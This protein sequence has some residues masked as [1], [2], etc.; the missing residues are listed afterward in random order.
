MSWWR[1]LLNLPPKG[2]HWA[3]QRRT[4]Q[5]GP[6]G[7]AS[8]PAEHRTGVVGTPRW[9]GVTHASAST[10]RSRAIQCATTARRGW[11]DGASSPTPATAG[12]ARTTAP[13]VSRH[14]AAR[15]APAR[16]APAAIAAR[17]TRGPEPLR[18]PLE[19]NQTPWSTEPES[20]FSTWARRFF[21]G[22]VVAV[23][24]LAAISGVR[25][26]IRP[27]NGSRR[28]VISGQSGYP[29]RTR[30]A[31]SRPG[32]PVSYLNWDE[33][34]PD[35]RPAQLSLDLASGLDPRS[36]WNGRGKQTAAPAYAG[37]VKVDSGRRR[38]GRRRPRAGA[39]VHQERPGW[40]GRR[41]QLAALAVPVARTPSSGRRQRPSPT[42]VA[43]RPGR[44]AG[45][46]A[47]RARVPD[48]DL[49]AATLKDAEAFFSAYAESDT[50][51]PR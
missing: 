46:H 18:A 51:C 14:R 45:Q 35:A 41:V 21:R 47:G 13:A 43:G 12:T 11:S 1:T 15:P 17:S 22:L 34:N 31:R 32:S 9:T 5:R 2:E 49:T 16:A 44:A 23:L 24:L 29:G 39:P 38:R 7:R 48:D 26:W 28:A 30:P 42:Y 36:G 25:S 6:R 3:D 19:P 4:K 8:T 50:R 10:G 27:N 37:E 33:T 40:A 20:S